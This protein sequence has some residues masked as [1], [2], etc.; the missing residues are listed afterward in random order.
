MIDR[1]IDV[2]HAGSVHELDD[3]EPIP[4]KIPG[5]EDLV[6]FE[7]NLL[8]QRHIGYENI[9]RIPRLIVFKGCRQEIGNVRGHLIVKLVT[10]R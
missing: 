7:I 9:A 8:R 4:Q 5:C 6:S 1:L 3:F 2:A 10:S